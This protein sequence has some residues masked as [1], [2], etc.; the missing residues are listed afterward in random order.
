MKKLKIGFLVIGIL[1]A[2]GACMKSSIEIPVQE[3]ALDYIASDCPKDV[4]FFTSASNPITS[5]EGL[6]DNEI[7]IWG[8]ELLSCVQGARQIIDKAEPHGLQVIGTGNAD[9]KFDQNATLRL[10]V[11]HEDYAED[12]IDGGGVR[13]IFVG[14]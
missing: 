9:A 5:L 1:I 13:I 12:I 2:L 11:T 4:V 10:F 8:L 7:A 6:K 3:D 14:E